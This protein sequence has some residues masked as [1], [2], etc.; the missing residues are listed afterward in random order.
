M[1]APALGAGDHHVVVVDNDGPRAVGVEE[2]AVDAA[3]A[4]DQ[5]V[6]LGGLAQPLLLLPA[7]GGDERAVLAERAVHEVGDV[8]GGAALLFRMAPGG[9]LLG[10]EVVVDEG[11]SFVHELEVRPA[12][13]GIAFRGRF[14]PCAFDGAFAQQNERVAGP[15]GIA[16][17]HEDRFHGCI[18]LGADDVVQFQGMDRREGLS[19]P[20]LIA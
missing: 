11:A 16:A 19:D 5:A 1:A 3:D 15:D 2:I 6:G 18:L 10:A 8:L 20:H 17:G 7:R 14:G 12:R 13:I 9:D 4:H